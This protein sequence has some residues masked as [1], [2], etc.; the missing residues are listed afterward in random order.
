MDIDDILAEIDS[1]NIPQETRDLHELTRAWVAE[2]AAP[3]L[4]PWPE[5]LMGRMTERIRR[6]VRQSTLS[7]LIPQLRPPRTQP[8]FTPS[9]I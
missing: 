1:D 9:R 4:L 7:P 2:R 5:P 3:E 6:Q 8:P